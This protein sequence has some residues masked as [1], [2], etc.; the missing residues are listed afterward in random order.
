MSNTTCDYCGWWNSGTRA[1]CSSCGKPLKKTV[2]YIPK[3]QK[4][5][6]IKV[7]QGISFGA[8]VG[9]VNIHAIFPVNKPTP[10]TIGFTP[11][12]FA[13]PCPPSPEHGFVES[14]IVKSQEDLE[15]LRQETLAVNAESEILIMP[16]VNAEINMI[17]TPGLLTVGPGHDGATSGKGVISF[18]LA[19]LNPIPKIHLNSADI[20]DEKWPYL[21]AVKGKGTSNYDGYAV[22]PEVTQLRSGP[23]LK[24]IS[25][26]FI[27]EEITVGV[28]TKTNGEDL[29]EW[30]KKVK[31][32]AAANKQSEGQPQEV[33]WHPTG[34]ITDHFSVHCREQGV[35]IMLSREPVVGEVLAPKPLDPP[36]AEAMKLGVIAGNIWIPAQHERQNAIVLALLSLHNSVALRGPYSFWLGVAASILLRFGSAGLRGEA[37][38]AHN[39]TSKIRSDVYD[40]YIPKSISFHRAA[41]SRVTQILTYGFGDPEAAHSFGGKKWGACGAS[42]APLFNAVRDLF[43]EPSSERA[44]ALIQATNVVVNQAHNGGWWLNKFCT[45]TA[46]NEIPTGSI[47]WTLQASKSIWEVGKL[48]EKA[49]E[50][51]PKMTKEIQ[52]WPPTRIASLRWRNA[53]LDVTP[54]A[55][56]LN[57]KAAT[58]PTAMQIA[59]PVTPA[60]L[61]SLIKQVGKVEMDHGEVSFITPDG[62]KLPVWHEVILDPEAT[63]LK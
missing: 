27:P 24:V 63:Q 56:I 39:A 49:L 51:L 21:E 7:I 32:I 18:P 20:S 5:K 44:S 42:L 37:R 17:W 8:S 61:K 60:L 29:L 59:V 34:G 47:G 50:L 13:R 15:K 36:D 40:F 10:T 9:A 16:L 6:G 14:R 4:A 2:S 22:N 25:Q 26:D 33:V 58:V 35:P 3:T 52:S 28:I 31:L 62:V 38:H 46:Y 55:F 19:G 53:S 41:L 54:G 12:P 11:P 57:L 23:I 48:K 43:L 45:Q 1:N 30:A